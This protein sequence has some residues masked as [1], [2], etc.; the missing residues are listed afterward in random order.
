M[1]L[2]AY[3]HELVQQEVN[4]RVFDL[5][6][7]IDKNGKPGY[8]K[9]NHKHIGHSVSDKELS[10]DIE[11]AD[12]SNLKQAAQTIVSSVVNLKTNQKTKPVKCHTLF[13]DIKSLRI[14]NKPVGKLEP[15]LLKHFERLETLVLIDNNTNDLNDNDLRNLPSNLLTLTIQANK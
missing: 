15:S 8:K 6:D 7:F 11:W 14:I 5:P 13:S 1:S 10:K 9:P 4:E 2:L 3:A 12:Q